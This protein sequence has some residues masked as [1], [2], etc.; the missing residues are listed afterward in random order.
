MFSSMDPLGEVEHV[1]G[2]EGLAVLGEDSSF[3]PRRPSNQ[4][5]SALEQWSVWRM[6]GTP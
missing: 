6:T 2:E 1:R 4:G 5:R 3:A